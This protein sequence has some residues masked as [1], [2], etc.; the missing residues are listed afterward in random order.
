M[1]GCFRCNCT[2][3]MAR[4]PNCPAFN[5]KCNACGGIGHFAICCKTKERELLTRDDE[6]RNNSRVRAYQLS[7]DQLL[8]NK[9]IIRL[10]LILERHAM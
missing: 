9:I 2:D 5:R 6:G 7:E 4:D 1:E 3:Y 10:Q 8:A